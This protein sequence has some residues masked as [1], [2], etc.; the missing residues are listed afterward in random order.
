MRHTRISY[1]YCYTRP[2][3]D[4]HRLKHFLR[5]SSTFFRFTRIIFKNI[6]SSR[7]RRASFEAAVKQSLTRQSFREGCLTKLQKYYRKKPDQEITPDTKL[8]HAYRATGARVPKML[9]VGRPNAPPSGGPNGPNSS[10]RRRAGPG[11]SPSVKR[12]AQLT[13]VRGQLDPVGAA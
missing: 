8:A 5:C 9:R 11:R 13:P 10:R 6:S 3:F 12:A 4:E 1:C 7:K 2:K